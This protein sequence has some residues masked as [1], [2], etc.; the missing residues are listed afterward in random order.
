MKHPQPRRPHSATPFRAKASTLAIVAALAGFASAPAFAAEPTA[1]VR[2]YTIPAG[3]L[4]DVLAQYAASAEVQL[5]VNP[6]VVDKARTSAGLKG[7]YSVQAGFAALLAGTGLEAFRQ[8]DGSFRLRAAPVAAAE[9]VL[10]AI[11]V[12]AT[13]FRET[14]LDDES[15]PVSVIGREAIQTRMPTSVVEAMKDAPGVG[16]SRAGGLGGQLVMRGVNSN[17][18]K[19]PLAINGERFRGRN[20]LEYNFIDPASVE[21]IEIIRGPVAAIYGSE[22]MAGMVNVVTRKPRPNFDDEFS[23][24]L[25]SLGVAYETV[26]DLFATRLEAEGGGKGFDLRIGVSGRKAGDYETPRGTATNSDFRSGQLDGTVGYSFNPD[27]RLELNFKLADANSNR[28]G[29]LGGAPG[30][31]APLTSRVNLREDPNREKYLGLAYSGK[32]DIK[33]IN[34][35]DASLYRRS[36]YTE[37][38]TT[39]YPNATSVS[40]TRTYVGG[41]IMHGGKAMLVSDAL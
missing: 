19:I 27:H 28:A 2:Q 4:G 16:F 11:T 22:A 9:M 29:G 31:D 40:K 33:G 8:G 32:P 7:S 15:K 36:L 17:D 12:T 34:R 24:G 37:L 6:A 21:R 18:L 10:P 3:N 26:N 5:V 35:I 38:V 41:P 23:F 25:S 30:M 39:R 14:F 20:T 13:N 1:T